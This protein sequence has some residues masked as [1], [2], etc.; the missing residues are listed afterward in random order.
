[1]L[2][3]RDG[4]LFEDVHLNI[5]YYSRRGV[6]V[7]AREGIETIKV[8]HFRQ[9]K[10]TSV[11]TAVIILPSNF[12]LKHLRPPLPDPDHREMDVPDYD[13]NFPILGLYRKLSEF[14]EAHFPLEAKPKEEQDSNY[15]LVMEDT[16]ETEW[17]REARNLYLRTF[18]DMCAECPVVKENKKFSTLLHI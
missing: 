10:R 11:L 3:K 12:E 1:M 8:D 9:D 15:K 13:R 6:T 7:K 18:V 16:E 2:S 5:G 14:H 4:E 17:M